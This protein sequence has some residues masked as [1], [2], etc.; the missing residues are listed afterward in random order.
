MLQRTLVQTLGRRSTMINAG[1]VDAS[2]RRLNRFN[3]P[4]SH[5]GPN[6]AHTNIP[7][8]D[9]YPELKR[10]GFEPGEKAQLAHQNVRQFPDWYKPYGFNY[11]GDGWLAFI[12]GGFFVMGTM[13][14]NDI[15]EAKGRRSRKIF[16][17]NRD[18]VK[19]WNHNATYKWAKDRIEKEDPN[20][21]K[22][23][24]GKTHRASAGHH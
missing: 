9:V 20:W 6:S 22:F 15:K 24:P 10:T 16:S 1:V 3:Y 11:M 19:H 18:D 17:L 5:A 21:T 7:Q 2:T 8:K 23:L 4:H 13:Y 12:L 14:M